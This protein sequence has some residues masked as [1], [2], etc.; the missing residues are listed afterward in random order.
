MVVGNKGMPVG[1]HLM[2]AL[3]S[4]PSTKGNRPVKNSEVQVMEKPGVSFRKDP[5]TDKDTIS[6]AVQGTEHTPYQ[7]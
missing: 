2:Q 7:V 1:K 3:V 4:L 6:N 5:Q